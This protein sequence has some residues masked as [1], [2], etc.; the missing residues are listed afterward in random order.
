[1][2]KIVS[3]ILGFYSLQCFDDLV[4]KK[5]GILNVYENDLDAV[6]S[7]FF[8]VQDRE[9]RSQYYSVYPS[10]VRCLFRLILYFFFNISIL[11]DEIK[12]Y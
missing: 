9:P 2:L 1:M 12:I 11:F 10:T 7:R 3:T 8:Y 5:Y 6:K 4:F